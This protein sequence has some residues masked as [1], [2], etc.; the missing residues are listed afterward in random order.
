MP[1]DV[2]WG[3]VGE[4]ATVEVREAVLFTGTLITPE[5]T[6]NVL[7][8]TAL[9][10]PSATAIKHIVEETGAWL[11]EMDETLNRS[12]R[13]E[14]EIPEGIKVMVASLHGAHLRLDEPGKNAGSPQERPGE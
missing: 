8:K 13:Q 3:M 12:I 10:Q 6:V 1:L 7:E 9:I 14:E 4:F 2:M 11:V 5:E